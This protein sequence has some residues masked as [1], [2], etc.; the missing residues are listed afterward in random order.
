MANLNRFQSLPTNRLIGRPPGGT[1]AFFAIAVFQ[2]R[3]QNLIMN[4]IGGMMRC[5]VDMCPF[6]QRSE[7]GLLI[8]NGLYEKGISKGLLRTASP[9]HTF[10]TLPFD[11]DECKLA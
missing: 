8:G 10:I 6:V 9:K 2:N 4:L 5:S 7:L 11:C 3:G 1:D